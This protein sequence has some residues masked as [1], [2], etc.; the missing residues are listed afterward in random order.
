M[1]LTVLIPSYN[2]VKNL[3]ELILKL[4]LPLKKITLPSWEILVIERDSTVQTVAVARKHGAHV[5]V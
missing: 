2:E 5:F 4:S 1:D 3:K